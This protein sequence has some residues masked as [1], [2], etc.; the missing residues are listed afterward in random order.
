MENNVRRKHNSVYKILTLAEW[1]KIEKVGKILLSDLDRRSGFVHLSTSEQV[2]ENEI[3][4]QDLISI[5]Q[6]LETCNRYFCSE[7]AVLAIEIKVQEIEKELRWD[8]VLARQNQKFPH[9]YRELRFSDIHALQY[10]RFENANWTFGKR[11]IW[12]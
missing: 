8:T 10:I 2:L 6:V 4:I 5:E 12:E 11:V 1:N 3:I 7:E 9:L